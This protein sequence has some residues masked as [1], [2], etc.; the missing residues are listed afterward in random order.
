[1]YLDANI[2]YGWRMS[3]KLSVNGFNWEKNVSKFDEDFTK[4]YD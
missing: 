4:N 3:Q 1:M 2:L